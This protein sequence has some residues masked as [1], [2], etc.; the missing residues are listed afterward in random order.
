VILIRLHGL[1]SVEKVNRVVTAVAN[2]PDELV[3]TFTVVDAQNT[4]RRS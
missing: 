3:R 4:R 2:E 1:E